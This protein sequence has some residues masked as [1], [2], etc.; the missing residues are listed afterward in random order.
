M[1]AFQGVEYSE[2]FSFRLCYVCYSLGGWV[3]FSANKS[4]EFRQIDA[5]TDAI[6]IFLW[7]H[8]YWGAPFSGLRNWGD[9]ALADEKVDLALK[10]VPVGVRDCSRSSDAEWSGVG[11]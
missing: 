10:L 9:D 4:V 3:T 11:R 6:G 5:H 8:H 2:I 1:I 7:R